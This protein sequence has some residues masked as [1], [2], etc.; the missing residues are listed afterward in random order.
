LRRKTLGADVRWTTF[1]DFL[2][3]FSVALRFRLRPRQSIVKLGKPA[4]LFSN[5]NHGSI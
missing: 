3:S 2:F 5:V 1:V 4:G